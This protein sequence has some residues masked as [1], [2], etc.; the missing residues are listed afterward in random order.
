MSQNKQQNRVLKSK[1]NQQ[2]KKYN[3]NLLIPSV[4]ATKIATAHW[5]AAVAL[6]VAAILILAIS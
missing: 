5:S 2:S 4:S 6:A 3:T 1:R